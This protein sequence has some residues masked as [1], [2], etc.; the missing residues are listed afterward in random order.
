MQLAIPV[1]SREWVRWQRTLIQSRFL[2]EQIAFQMSVLVCHDLPELHA[3]LRES[4]RQL[5]VLMVECER[6]LDGRES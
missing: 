3:V 6:Q 2:R 1:A 4:M 5:D